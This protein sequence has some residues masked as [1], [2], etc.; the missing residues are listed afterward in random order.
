ME[1][2]KLLLV[3]ISVGIFLII[4]IGFSILIFS[5][6]KNAQAAASRPIRAGAS[7]IEGE[8]TPARTQPAT[9]DAVD[10]IR[11]REGVQGL[12]SPP[13]PVSAGEN[14]GYAGENP[15]QSRTEEKAANLVV[16]VPKPSVTVSSTAPKSV[17]VPASQPKPAVTPKQ[18]VVQPTAKVEPKSTVTPA[19]KPQATPVAV[20]RTQQAPVA[21]RPAV[22]Q[23]A[24][25]YWVQAGAYSTQ[26]R[27]EGVKEQLSAKGITAIIEN[28]DVNGKRV[29]RVRV[30][31][32]TSQNE[33]D[34]WVT[35]IRAING[36]EDSQVRT[37]QH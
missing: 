13:P 4:V 9:V 21:A 22:R 29:Y 16:A 2:K 37:S 32:Y 31:P 20:S 7:G 23:Q 28:G 12:Q 25:D 34:Y 36:F 19:A 17:S 27:A 8:S 11:N 5:P 33:A 3:A 18:S 30:G 35:L 1:K 14:N 26:V 15:S 6:K 10:M 24:T